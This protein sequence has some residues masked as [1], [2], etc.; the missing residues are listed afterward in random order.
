[1]KILNITLLAFLTYLPLSAQM[2]EKV[3]PTEIS[4]PPYAIGNLVVEQGYYIDRGAELPRINFRIVDNLV[5]VYWI[6]EDG[7]IAEPEFNS[8]IVRFN[9]TV[10]TSRRDYFHLTMLPGSS[11]LGSPGVAL[12]PHLYNVVLVFPAD[13]GEEPLSYS[14]FYN[15]S[16]GE[17]V[18][19]TAG[20]GS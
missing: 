6:D 19:P 4:Q 12:P 15:S 16:M 8:A 20:D 2:E 18:D 14:F 17:E 3:I 1:M 11:G 10:R 13:E 9:L 7:L 5:R